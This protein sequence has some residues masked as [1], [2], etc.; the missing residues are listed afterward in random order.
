LNAGGECAFERD[1]DEGIG[2]S[3]ETAGGFA[4]RLRVDGGDVENVRIILDKILQQARHLRGVRDFVDILN[5]AGEGEKL[6]LAEE[7][8]AEA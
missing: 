8:F 6:A 2:V 5:P 4:F 3:A 1:F 7:L